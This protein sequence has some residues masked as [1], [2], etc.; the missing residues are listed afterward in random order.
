MRKYRLPLFIM[1]FAILGGALLLCNN[2][3]SVRLLADDETYVIHLGDKVTVSDRR[4]SYDSEYQDVKGKII[5]PD[6]GAY[7]GREFT[8]KQHGQYQVVYEAYFGH[9]LETKT[10]TYICQR[11]SMDY[12]TSN[13]SASIS[14]G[15]FR[16]N[17]EEYTHQGVIIDVKNGAEIKFTEPLDMADFMIPQHIEPGKTYLDPSTGKDSNSLIDFIVDPNEQMSFDFTGLSI[18]LTDTENPDNYVEIRVK[19]SGFSNYLAGALSYTKVGFSGGF[20]GGWEYNWQTGIPGDGKLSDTGTGLAMSFKGQPYQDMLHSGQILF[21]YSNYRFYTYPG[22]LSHNQVF[23]INDLDDPNFYKETVWQGFTCGKCY[24]SITPFNFYN[25][26][27]RI[28]IKSVGKF[29]LTSEEMPDDT[30][31]VI[32]IDY[33]NQEATNLPKAVVGGYY[34]IFNSVVIDNYDTNLKADVFVTYRDPINEKDIDVSIVDNKF[35]ASKEGTYYINYHAKDR[36]GNIADPVVL[37]VDTIDSVNDINIIL[38]GESTSCHVLDEATFPTLEEVTTTGGSGNVKVTYEVVDP[39]GQLVETK[40]FKFK[41]NLVGDYR[42][43]YTAT[44]YLGHV[45]EK[46]FVIH[47]L[48]LEAPVIVGNISLPKALISG[49][50]YKFDSVKA[51]ETRNDEVV[52]MFTDILVNGDVYQGSVIATGT[53]MMVEHVANG[54]SGVTKETFRIPVIDVSDPINQI[55]QSKYFYGDMT[56]T[57]NQDDVTLGVNNNE[58]TTLFINKLD[59]ASFAVNFELIPELTNFKAVQVKLIDAKDFTKTASVI[60]DFINGKASIPGLDGLSYAISS[61]GTQL[62]LSFNDVANRLYD[63]LG[64]EISPL[65]IYDDG[66]PFIGFDNGVYVELSLCDLTAYSEIKVTRIN[67]QALGYKERSG[68]EAKPTIRLNGLLKARQT[69]GQDFQYPTFEAYDV[70]S[71]VDS[72]SIIISKPDG[73]SVRG[74][75]HMTETFVIDAYGRYG[76]NYQASDTWGNT[77]RVSNAIF[78]YD[79]VCP[80][81]EVSGLSKDTYSVGDVVEIPGY[82]VSDN[83]G[84]YS[85]DVFLILPTN[86]QRILTHDENGVVTYA[87]TDSSI[88]NSSFIVNNHS[89]RT[90]MKGRHTLRYVAYDEEFNTT[91]VELTFTV[92]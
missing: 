58:D 6:G 46:T 62:S 64:N 53:E 34:P 5:L 16:H 1:S 35:L 11:R 45:S 79:D 55:D 31:P 29:D 41:P 4:I 17:T 48:A 8:A 89:F 77:V 12:F 76:L 42:V 23:F 32:N 19:D 91:V 69:Y 36:S 81:L 38:P 90:E 66:E 78:V 88:Y 25:S 67:N 87:L 84:N 27:G 73:T 18:K 56:A 52:E 63:T 74:D 39:K 85:V 40:D 65:A 33:D 70:L 43:I 28:L 20:L 26:T 75:N 54:E 22:S 68:D 80:S 2:E 44:D 3:S 82:K 9:H 7:N 51:I 13:D 60:I 15:E 57:F 50:T 24:V 61:T 30:K 86:E 71:E 21:D 49:F 47:S 83:K 72:A 92:K 14:Y 37:R 10:I 59:A